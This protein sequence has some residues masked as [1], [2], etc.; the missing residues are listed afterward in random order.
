V[1]SFVYA[2]GSIAFNPSAPSGSLQSPADGAEL[3]VSSVDFTVDVSDPDFGTAQGD[4]INA[5]LYADGSVAGSQTVTSNNTVTVTEEIS[6]GGDHIYYWELTDSYGETTTTATRNISVPSDLTFRNEKN[7]DEIL[8]SV[9]VNVT[10]YYGGET[11]ERNTTNGVLDLSGF[12]V[13]EPI[14]IRA[15]G[16]NY[17]TRVVVIESIYEQSNVYL[18]N[19]SVP[20]YS[21]RF[22]LQD[23]TGEYPRS[24]TVLF[25]ERALPLNNSTEW[26]VITGDE[27]GVQGVPA[28]IEQDQRYRLRLKNLNTGTTATIGAYTA[29]QSE[30]VTISPGSATIEIPNSSKAYGWSVT[31]NE[32]QQHILFEYLDTEGETD[33]VTITIHERF[34]K[35]NVLV[36]NETFTGSNNIVYQ[37]PLAANQTNKTWMAEIYVER[38]GETYHFREAV[39]GPTVSIIPQGLDS[40]WRTSVGVFVLLITG[41]VFSGLNQ[42]T[43]AIATAMVGGMLWQIGLLSGVATG[44]A[45]VL[46]IAISIVNHYRGGG[47]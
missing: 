27:F 3:T 28:T 36:D 14:I 33:S 16:E 7:P 9:Q 42:S 15:T 26:R 43:G 11:V 2:D 40:V 20:T 13:D 23:P 17:A 24:D 41:M 1:P 8:D 29:V 21:V 12:P 37:T 25:V 47:A 35:S 44:P 31:E 34:N 38:G 18:L 19:D 39:T 45:I 32:S 30:T 4:S 5:T 46:A 6:S 10:A 22:D